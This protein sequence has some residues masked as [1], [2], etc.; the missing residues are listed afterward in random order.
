MRGTV[1]AVHGRPKAEVFEALGLTDLGEPSELL[2]GD[3]PSYV[4]LPSGWLLI[5]SGDDDFGPE[6]AAEVSETFG[7]VGGCE[8]TTVTMCSETAMYRD[9]S[10]V[11]SVA[12]DPEEGYDHLAIEG[13]P[14][15]ELKTLRKRAAI[16][17]AQED[18]EEPEVDVFYDVPIDL[19]GKAFGFEINAWMN[20]EADEPAFT[21]LTWPRPA[22]RS[23]EAVTSGSETTLGAVS[24]GGFLSAFFGFFRKR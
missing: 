2:T 15:A 19:A 8:F 4:E 1:L 3:G 6:K 23:P 5:V 10:L 17:Q 7:L 18:P 16:E 11:W 24:N 14:P 20:G 22:S 21:A 9:G 12:H 13:A